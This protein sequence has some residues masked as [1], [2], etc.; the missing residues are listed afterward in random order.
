VQA[1]SQ[2]EVDVLQNKKPANKACTGRWGFCSIFEQFSGFEFYLLSSR[3]HTPP[4]R[5]RTPLGG[6]SVQKGDHD[7]K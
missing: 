6:Q 1:Q 3:I 2:P 7:E 5:Q 4:R